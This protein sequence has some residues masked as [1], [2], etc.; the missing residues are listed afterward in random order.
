MTKKHKR[1]KLFIHKLL[2]L[3]INAC[4]LFELCYHG[5][6]MHGNRNQLTPTFHCKQKYRFPINISTQRILRNII[7]TYTKWSMNE[8][9]LLFPGFDL[10]LEK[11]T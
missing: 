11:L 5:E 2:A 7:K 4:N 9:L 10:T 6:T 8:K 3:E 1:H